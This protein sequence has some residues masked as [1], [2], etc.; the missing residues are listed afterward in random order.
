[1]C[2]KREAATGSTK[3]INF[4]LFSDKQVS[5]ALG[6]TPEFVNKSETLVR[7]KIVFLEKKEMDCKK[8][9]AHTYTGC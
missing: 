5:A 8:C 3:E 7:L 1:V 2:P 6:N 4:L 9:D